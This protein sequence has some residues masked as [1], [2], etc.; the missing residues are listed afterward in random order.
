MYVYVC[1][2]APTMPHRELFSQRVS[3]RLPIAFARGVRVVDD[4]IVRCNG[5]NA[6]EPM[7]RLFPLAR[8][9]N[10]VHRYALLDVNALEDHIL[11]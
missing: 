11:R 2:R 5:L 3:P 7:K 8:L 9:V 1:A 10:E 4:D 6:C